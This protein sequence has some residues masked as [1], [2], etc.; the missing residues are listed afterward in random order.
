[1]EKVVCFVGHSNS[2]KTTFLEKVVK[3]L[4]WR[5]CRVAV[6]KHTPHGFDMDHPGKDSWRLSHAGADV[7]AV[8]S[9]QTAAVIYNKDRELSLEEFVEMAGPR[10]DLILA[11][12]YK[13][14]RYPKIEFCHKGIPHRLLSPRSELLAVV[15]EAL[16]DISVPQFHPDDVKGMANLLVEMP[17]R[18]FA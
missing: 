4:K 9:P 17:C 7:V 13:D 5:G 12:G 3:E 16:L 8:S 11:E 6:I 14:C 10:V 15:S 2:G 1:M 18:V